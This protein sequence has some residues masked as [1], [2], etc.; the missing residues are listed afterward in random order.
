MHSSRSRQ[1]ERL[2]PY[3]LLPMQPLACRRVWQSDTWRK[4]KEG[5]EEV[6]K[7]ES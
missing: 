1:L 2:L 5:S 3:K 7:S 6:V 4:A